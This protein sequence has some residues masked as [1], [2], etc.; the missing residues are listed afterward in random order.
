MKEW[1]FYVDEEQVYWL[2]YKEAGYIYYVALEEEVLEDAEIGVEYCLSQS[3]FNSWAD[4]VVYYKKFNAKPCNFSDIPD[5]TKKKLPAKVFW[6]C[7]KA[8]K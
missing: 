8:S 2:A 1:R 6:Q 4:F 7:V 5:T 3:N